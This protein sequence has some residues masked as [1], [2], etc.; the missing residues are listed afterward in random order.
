M[1]SKKMAHNSK[2]QTKHMLIE[3]SSLSSISHHFQ[4]MSYHSNNP[5]IT[6]IPINIYKLII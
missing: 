5:P 2:S 1:I 6:I 4:T 3:V